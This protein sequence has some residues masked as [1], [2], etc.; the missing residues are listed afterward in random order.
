MRAIAGKAGKATP[1]IPFRRLRSQLIS[2]IVSFLLTYL[3]LAILI[4]SSDVYGHVPDSSSDMLLLLLMAVFLQ[5]SYY[6]IVAS[7]W[8]FIEL[9]HRAK[10]GG[11]KEV[12]EGIG[13]AL[14]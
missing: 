9:E 7:A 14:S 1:P 5:L 11:G 8:Q 3:N 13:F 4:L 2:V 6:A 12:G 10:R